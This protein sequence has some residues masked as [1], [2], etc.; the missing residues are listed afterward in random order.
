MHPCDVEDGADLLDTMSLGTDEVGSRVGKDQ[1]G[2]WK[3][4]RAE[5]LLETLD[6]N[7]V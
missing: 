7:A 3:T 4:A 6:L 5:F 2:G 1:L